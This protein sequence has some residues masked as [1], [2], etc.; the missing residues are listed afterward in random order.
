MTKFFS[1]VLGLCSVLRFQFIFGKQSQTFFKGRLEI[2][3]EFTPN[4][5][6]SHIAKALNFFLVSRD[7]KNKEKRV[8]AL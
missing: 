1:S 2:I 8:R 4:S 6:D 5:V 7:S 3:L